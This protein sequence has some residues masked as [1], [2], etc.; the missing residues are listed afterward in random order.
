[1]KV[2][3]NSGFFFLGI[4]TSQVGHS[5]HVSRWPWQGPPQRSQEVSQKRYFETT[6]DFPLKSWHGNILVAPENRPKPKKE[7]IVFQL[8]IL[9]CYVSFREGMN[10]LFLWLNII[11]P[12]DGWIDDW[13]LQSPLRCAIIKQSVIRYPDSKRNPWSSKLYQHL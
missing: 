13:K 8:S 3:M 1:M 7:T 2:V 11:D 4:L 9:R 12:R 6:S 5:P 10:L